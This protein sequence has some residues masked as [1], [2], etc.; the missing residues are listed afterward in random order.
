MP[1]AKAI[2]TLI[3]LDIIGEGFV[4]RLTRVMLFGDV[5]NGKAI[6]QFFRRFD[7]GSV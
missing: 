7:F 5:G 1:Q 4:N 2:I 3:F 6:V